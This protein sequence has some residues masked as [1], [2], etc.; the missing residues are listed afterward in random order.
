MPYRPAGAPVVAVLMLV[1]ACSDPNAIPAQGSPQH[2]MHIHLYQ[3]PKRFSP[4]DP[5]S[6]PDQQVMTL[7][8]D[9]LLTVDDT[10]AYV[11]RLAERWEVAADRITFHL[12]PGLRWS[13][14]T[15]FG[16]GDVLFTYRLLADPRSGSAMAGKLAGAAFEA[17]DDTTFVIRPARPNV[18]FLSLLAGP[19]AFILP[20]HVLGRVPVHEIAGHAFF[21]APTVG[22]GPYVFVRH[23]TDQYVELAAN[24][25]YRKP[26]AIPRIFLRPVGSDAATAQLG[27]GEMDLVQISPTDLPVVEQFEGVTVS[28]RPSPGFI[29]IAVDL[30]DRRFADP[31]VRR[32]MLHAID[33]EALVAKLLAGRG[34]VQNSSF[35]TPW[36]LP[37]TLEEYAHD[38]ARARALLAEAGWRAGEKV[39][40]SWI[41]GQR[42]RDTT[43]TVVQGAL[44]AAGMAVEL[45]QV[46]AAELLESY[47]KR[48]FDLA[49]FGGGGYAVDPSASAMILGCTDFY[50]VGGNISN[51]C[52]TSL[53]ALTTRADALTD[54]DRRAELYREAARKDNAQVP[55]L[56]LYNPDTLWATSARLR[57]FRGGGDFTAG[58]WNADEWTL[59]G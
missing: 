59:A 55:Y 37:G 53:D 5:P 12:R 10:Y 47:Q 3:K 7:I 40:L 26:V 24:P 22:M 13:D 32:A 39:T 14:G 19:F 4:L 8:F 6:G 23:K 35:V 56:W 49:L 54:H 16:S 33:R 51:F 52:D 30:S 36:A 57:G 20:E 9:N 38:P 2:A 11:P 41:P 34:R 43:A 21:S 25:H 42:D 58:F 18:G 27:T 48:T 46:Q 29:R 44:S 15:P 1:A 17:P 50:P 45:R 31:R 28:A